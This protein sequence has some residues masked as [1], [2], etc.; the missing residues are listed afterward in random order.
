MEVGTPSKADPPVKKKDA[1]DFESDDSEP[2]IIL[3]RVSL[4]SKKS[5]LKPLRCQTPPAAT[6]A[7][8][9]RSN[10]RPGTPKQGS[11]PTTPRGK[12]L[13]DKLELES[14]KVVNDKCPNSK[15]DKEKKPVKPRAKK[16]KDADQTEKPSKQNNIAP[17]S[18]Q[19]KPPKGSASKKDVEELEKNGLNENPDEKLLNFAKSNGEIE[20]DKPVDKIPQSNN[21]K[22]VYKKKQ[23]IKDTNTVEGAELQQ[24]NGTETSTKCEQQGVNENEVGSLEGVEKDDQNKTT[25]SLDLNKASRN[26]QNVDTGKTEKNAKGKTRSP[27][28]AKSEL[29]LKENN[30]KKKS[31]NKSNVTPLSPKK[32]DATS[33]ES[34]SQKKESPKNDSPPDKSDSLV[35]TDGEKSAESSSPKTKAIKPKVVHYCKNCNYSAMSKAAVTRHG[36]T[37]SSQSNT[38]NSSREDSDRNLDDNNKETVDTDSKRQVD[39]LTGSTDGEDGTIDKCDDNEDKD[40]TLKNKTDDA[41]PA[42]SPEGAN[43]LTA[44]RCTHCNFSSENE[45]ELSKHLEKCQSD[46]HISYHCTMCNYKAKK[47]LLLLRHQQ[48][49]GVF[50]CSQCEYLGSDKDTLDE[51]SKQE[52]SQ[53]IGMK[54]CKLCNRYIKNK[55]NFEEHTSKCQGRQPL[56]CPEC[57][58]EFKV[59]LMSTL[60]F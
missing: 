38:S 16:I 49:H 1:Y 20:D 2:E 6:R 52:H 40:G 33:L 39:K 5:T 35:N 3:K 41:E 8:T 51:H 48:S 23:A 58:R 29:N 24:E 31:S 25:Q 46:K 56:I 14:S 26:D 18:R 22:R 44:N 59:R 10:S 4:S 55:V 15:N 27:K 43:V 36:K 19:K 60:K 7:T 9:P 45:D 21:K 32:S 50:A 47:R 54:F 37:C 57:S 30:M 34:D 42:K 11:R 13:A 12:A 17:K 28:A 53:R